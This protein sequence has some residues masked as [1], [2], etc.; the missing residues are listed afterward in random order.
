M[1]IVNIV[2]LSCYCCEPFGDDG[3][4]HAIPAPIRTTRDRHVRQPGE[5]TLIP[6]CGDRR[7]RPL[8]I[9][10]WRDGGPALRDPDELGIMD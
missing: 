8:D 10:T 5:V 1:V 4:G 2:S 9:I 7:L 3:G 6:K